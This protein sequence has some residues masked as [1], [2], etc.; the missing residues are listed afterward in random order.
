MILQQYYEERGQL[1]AEARQILD[2][3]TDE[4]TEQEVTQA[5][6]RHD[7]VMAKVDDLDN[8][9]KREERQLAA[10]NAEEERRSRQRPGRGDSS[11]PASDNPEGDEPTDE[12]RQGEYRNAFYAF[13]GAG[14]ELSGMSNEQRELLRVGYVEQRVQTAGTD[15]A[16]GYTVPTTLANRII[17]AM[18][19]WGPMYDPGVTDEMVTSSGNP[20]DMPTNDDTGNTGA[21]L[22]EGADI[23]DDG[24]GDFVF[25]EVSLAA[26]TRATPWVK[27]SY[28]LLQDSIFDLEGFIARKLGE[29]LGRLANRELTIGAGGANAARGIVTAATQGHAAASATAIAGDEVIDL[30]HSVNAAYRRSPSCRF[31][32]ADTTLAVLRKLKDGQGNYLWSMGDV[33]TEQPDLILGKPYSINDDCPAIATGAKSILFGDFSRYTVRKVGSPLVGTV[34][35]RFWPKVGLAGLIRFDGEMTDAGAVKA[36]VQA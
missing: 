9:I 26:F 14:C 19:D 13:F 2:A 18:L 28:E 22:A 20:F 1:V 6:E 35:E 11:A 7:A 4:S 36:L 32:F 5:E 15:A 21:A 25:G 29:R 24:S 27:L 31:M 34:R 33:R 10:E 3:V 30:Q 8:K 17:E 12:Q 16:G 23:V